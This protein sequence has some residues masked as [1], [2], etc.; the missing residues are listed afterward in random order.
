MKLGENLTLTPAYTGP[1][2]LNSIPNAQARIDELLSSQNVLNSDTK[3]ITDSLRADLQALI[4]NEN[5]DIQEVNNKLQILA[6]IFSKE[7]TAND[8]FDALVLLANTWNNSG[9]LI[10]TIEG[11]FNSQSGELNVDISMFNFG[12]KDDYKIVGSTDK[13]GAL[14]TVTGFEK[15]DEKTVVITAFDRACFVEDGI[16]YDAS[17]DGASFGITFSISYTRPQLSFNLSDET[18]EQTNV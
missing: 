17:V 15:L 2:V 6:D 4:D 11:V 14:N 10:Q 5:V 18:G 8:V 12:S 16:F 13:K 3:D 7:G 1:K 9:D